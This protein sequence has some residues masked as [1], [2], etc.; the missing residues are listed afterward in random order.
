[1]LLSLIVFSK[2]AKNLKKDNNNRDS[3]IVLRNPKK[4]EQSVI[5]QDQEPTCNT[6]GGAALR[7]GGLRSCFA[8][9]E[10]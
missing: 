3:V 4:S 5:T 2:S 1:M 6:E 7:V 9:C 10:L 8:S